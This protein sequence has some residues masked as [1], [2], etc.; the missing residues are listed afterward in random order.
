MGIYIQ[1]VPRSVNQL[2]VD[3]RSDELIFDQA[4]ESADGS[5]S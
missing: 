3:D 1:Y 2:L 4:C 5:W